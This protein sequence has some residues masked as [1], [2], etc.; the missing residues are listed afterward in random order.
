MAHAYKL[1]DFM[2]FPEAY[3]LRDIVILSYLGQRFPQP[4][5]SLTPF[6]I[7]FDDVQVQLLQF[8]KK[9]ITT[10]FI[11]ASLN[12]TLVSLGTL[13][14]GT[15]DKNSIIESKGCALIR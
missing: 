14:T 3:K 13:G 5:Q 2:F 10:K 4:I 15:I 9:C 12:M 6:S 1:Y 11:P 7:S 8:D